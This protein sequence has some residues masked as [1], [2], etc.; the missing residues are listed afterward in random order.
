MTSNLVP[1]ISSSPPP[2]ELDDDIPCSSSINESE[3]E[4]DDHDFGDFTTAEYCKDHKEPSNFNFD[5]ETKANGWDVTPECNGHEDLQDDD[6]GPHLSPPEEDFFPF[7]NSSNSEQCQV[8]VDQ[9]QDGDWADFGQAYPEDNG[10]FGE[11]NSF[12]ED[13]AAR[14]DDDFADFQEATPS[15][16]T[17]FLETTCPVGTLD[18]Q[19]GVHGVDRSAVVLVLGSAF[20]LA[21]GGLQDDE[22]DCECPVRKL[23]EVLTEKTNGYTN[24]AGSTVWANMCD[25]EKTNAL[26]YHWSRSRANERMMRSLN[27]DSRNI[28]HGS[29]WSS[30]IPAFAANLSNDLLQPQPAIPKENCATSTTTTSST[31]AVSKTVAS[32]VTSDI[33]PQ[34]N[35]DWNGSGLVNPLDG[36]ES[37][38]LRSDSQSPKAPG[39]GAK[40]GTLPLIEKIMSDAKMMTAFARKQGI[41]RNNLSPDA[42]RVLTE[43]PDLSFMK[44]KVLMFPIRSTTPP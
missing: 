2:L 44:S 9:D 27:I 6:Y 36:L 13:S 26:C 32:T 4:D 31:G 28:L 11:E 5:V 1:I 16:P 7:G 19:Y 25:V 10:E 34:A 17:E 20:P 33:I 8:P 21:S 38:F 41:R 15:A 35:F 43:L 23:D 18:S 12:A 40:S 30:S 37:E 42:Q 39:V 22:E 3:D 29:K 14:D 24:R